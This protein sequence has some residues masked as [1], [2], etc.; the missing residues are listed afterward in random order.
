MSHFIYHAS[1]G[2]QAHSRSLHSVTAATPWWHS[3]HTLQLNTLPHFHKLSQS[4]IPTTVEPRFTNIPEKW[5]STIMSTL[6]LV[7]NAIIYVCLQSNAVESF[8]SPNNTTWTVQ[9]SP[10]N[11]DLM[12][13]KNCV[14]PYCFALLHLSFFKFLYPSQ[15][16]GRTHS[17]VVFLAKQNVEVIAKW[18]CLVTSRG[19]V[20]LPRPA[21]LSNKYGQ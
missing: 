13:R 9:N 6:C 12:Y 7:P 17:T 4:T 20:V 21:F 8:F 14:P 15:F 3:L 11:L 16:N 2:P 18:V 5:P 1:L 19:V 10:D